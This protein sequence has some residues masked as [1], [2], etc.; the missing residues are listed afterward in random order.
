M[1][2]DYQI[3]DK[4]YYLSRYHE[5]VSEHNIAGI[6][7]VESLQRYWL[8]GM[9]GYVAKH[10]LFETK[11]EAEKFLDAWLDGVDFVDVMRD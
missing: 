2:S 1:K 8:S 6:C 9:F 7:F 4:V 11:E 5:K 3:G 10:D